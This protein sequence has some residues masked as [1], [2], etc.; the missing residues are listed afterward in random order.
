MMPQVEWAV[1]SGYPVIVMNPN[2]NDDPATKRKV[3]FNE[4]MGKHA[5]HVWRNYIEPSGFEKLLV[6]A[7]SAGGGCVTEIIHEFPETFFLKVK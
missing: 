3:P 2:Q 5:V 1:Q 4:N 7:H 6:L